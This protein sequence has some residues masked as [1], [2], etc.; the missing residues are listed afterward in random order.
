MIDVEDDQSIQEFVNENLA[1]PFKPGRG[2]YELT[3][4]SKVQS[5]KE[6]V[7]RD[8]RNGDMYTGKAARELVGLPGGEDARLK[9][10]ELER[11]DVF[12]QST[13]FNRK[14]LGGTKFL[15]EVNDFVE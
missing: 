3:K 1:A 4:S 15:Y 14:L 10:V 12:I 9:P 7:L 13:S 8:K 5:Y 6:I 2:F 11:F